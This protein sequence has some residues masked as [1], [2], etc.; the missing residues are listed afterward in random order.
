MGTR[1]V[2]PESGPREHPPVSDLAQWTSVLG[3]GL[4]FLAG[5]EV[6]YA[7]VDW[8]CAT[9]NAWTLH[10]AYAIV[11]ALTVGAGMLGRSLWTRIGGD[12][13]DSAAGSV[14]RSR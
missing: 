5:L 3:G 11:L 14:A 8:A 1:D 13:P 2:R 9:D 10:I 6:T 4:V 7:M 12:W